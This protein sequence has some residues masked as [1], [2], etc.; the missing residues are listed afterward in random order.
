MK[1][2]IPDIDDAVIGRNL[3]KFRQSRGMTQSKLASLIG[4][5]YQQLH[6]YE[7]GASSM[8]CIRLYAASQALGF[9]YDDFFGK[10]RDNASFRVPAVHPAI[11][12][13]ALKLQ[14]MGATSQRVKILKIID[15]LTG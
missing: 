10:P 13:R 12:I 2:P 3:K 4:I 5:S 6:K 15:I 7:T 14:N 1:A 9:P 8:S 11:M